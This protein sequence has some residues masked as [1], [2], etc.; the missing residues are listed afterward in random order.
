MKHSLLRNP[1]LLMI[2]ILLSAISVSVGE[3]IELDE[4]SVIG[5]TGSWAG[6][7]AWD[8]GQFRAQLV[9]DNQFED[10]IDESDQSPGDD[11]GG[12][13]LGKEGDE[14]ESFV[15]DLQQEYTID[16]IQLYNTHNATFDDRAT[17][18]YEIWGSNEIAAFDTG[19]VGEGGDDLVNA[20]LM[21]EG[22]MELA[23]FEDDPLQPQIANIADSGPFR[24]IRFST[25][26]PFHED[27]VI[28]A[29]RSVGINEIKVFGTLGGGVPFD[30]NNDGVLDISDLDLLSAEVKAGT[31]GAPF[32]V[33]GDGAVDAADI[34]AYVTDPDKL[35]TYVGDSNLD[36]EFNSSDFVGLFTAGEYE[37]G[38]AM[39]STWAT[40]DFNGDGDFDSGDFVVAFND[41]GFERGPRGASNVPEPVGFGFILIVL[42]CLLRQRIRL[43]D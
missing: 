4:D 11:N 12:F 20:R 27:D 33:T 28:L 41:G 2:G 23:F 18:G 17:F 35:N 37:D 38:V 36:G 40:G 3:Q 1:G 31:N 13:W 32:D 21:S 24:Y 34:V 15:L 14:E 7:Q 43:L 16:E 39:N 8:V 19:E 26:G 25:V 9:A 30:F 10:E 5:G 29:Q 22:E 42:G 6:E